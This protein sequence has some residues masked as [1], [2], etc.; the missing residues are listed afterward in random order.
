MHTLRSKGFALPT[1]LIASVVLLTVLAV[2]VTATAAVRTS[3]KT[4]YYTQLA[5]AA[6][7]AGVAYAKACLAEN[8]NEPTWSNDKPL[9]P[10]TDCFGNEALSPTLRVLVV[11]G[12][13]S[14]GDH[15]TRDT[16]TAGGG[17]G[18]GGLVFQEITASVGSTA[19]TVGAGGAQATNNAGNNG[20]NSVFGSITATG[21]GGGGNR[22]NDPKNGGSGG[23]KG[24]IGTAVGLGTVGQGNNGGTAPGVIF[25]GLGG[26][27]AGAPG[28]D[29]PTA[30][31]NLGPTDGGA[32]IDYS[33]VFGDEVGDEGWFAGGGGGGTSPN[34][35]SLNADGGRGGGGN[36]GLS[37]G[38]G[39]AGQANTGG[40]GGGASSNGTRGGAG[41]SG[42]VLVAYPLTS[43]IVASGGSEIVSGQYKVHIFD[44]NGTFTVDSVG[45]AACPSDPRCF[46]MQNGNVRSS[47]SVGM[48]TVDS[49]GKAVTIPNNGYVEITRT[50][51]NSVWRTYTQPAVQSAVV[52]DLCSGQASSSLGWNNAYIVSENLSIP[53]IEDASPIAINSTNAVYPGPQF[54]RKDFS[55]VTSGEYVLSSMAGA[56]Q[57]IFIDGERV[58]SP[59]TAKVIKNVDLDVGCHTL[60]VRLLNGSLVPNGSELRLTLRKAGTSTSIVKTDSSWRATAGNLVE[61]TQPNYF[62][63]PLW[64]QARSIAYIGTS[65]WTVEPTSWSSIT[66]DSSPYWVS[67]NHSFSG[68]T[69]PSNQTTYFINDH[70]W[71]VS[72]PT[73]FQFAL[74]CDDSCKLFVNGDQV[75]QEV[76]WGDV[77]TANVTLPAGK[78]RL[79]LELSNGSGPSAFLF[80]ARDLSGSTGSEGSIGGAWKAA[81]TWYSSPVSLY[82]Y[83]ADYLPEPNAGGSAAVDVVVVA[84]GGGGAGNCA[85]CGGGGGGGGGGVVRDTE[86]RVTVGSIPVVVGSGGNGGPA[87]S[88]GPGNA[89]GNGENSSFGRLV[90]IGGGGGQAQNSLS[91]V[92]GGSGGGGS[93]GGSPPPGSGGVG[94]FSQGNVGGSGVNS[95]YGGGGGGGAGGAGAS[96]T[97]KAGGAGRAFSLLGTTVYFGGGGGGGAYT[98][99]APGN[100]GSGGGGDGANQS[101]N[102]GNGYPG[103]ANT[104]GGGGGANGNNKGGGGGAGGSGVVIV[105]YPT[106]ALTATGGTVSTAGG[107]TFHTFNSSGSFTITAIN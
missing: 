29:N 85:S 89:G 87:G 31:D 15:S 101:V 44:A 25:S 54:F 30:N 39:A 23:G 69:Y 10:S 41:G 11:A 38:N 86:Y 12:G 84:G 50:T 77:S 37:G 90:A 98:T 64:T 21:G 91:G 4:Q 100:G 55:A 20:G 47:F 79:A 96:G 35:A 88:N 107:Y 94:M 7:E 17:G 65:P 97:S 26:G 13:G 49:D 52:P 42:V 3:L 106:G 58:V 72:T 57:E 56:T 99:Y 59:T 33:W 75:I 67:T 60:E 76:S 102:N 68:T 22:D 14:G 8:D 93:G 19:V 78:H 104:G 1:V 105:S 27:G 5:Q 34:Y 6:G 70:L 16:A 48:P 95:P 2:S 92:P 82:S 83:A 45:G 43:D 62:Q 53:E 81:N 74:A 103:A 36:G 80:A 46:V 40:G 32:G 66:Q 28:G 73:E 63:A 71:E 9:K 18:A 61:Y 24:Y 51:N